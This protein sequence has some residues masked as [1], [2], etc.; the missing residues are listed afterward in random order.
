M[1]VLQVASGAQSALLLGLAVLIGVLL[2]PKVHL[3]APVLSA[4]AEGRPALELLRPQLLPGLIG[5][6]AGASILVVVASVAPEPMHHLQPMVGLPA[7]AKLLYGGITEELML[8]WGFMTL[9]IWLLWRSGQRGSGVPS[10][11]VAWLGIGISAL[12]FGIGHLPAASALFGGLSASVVAY[13]VAGNAAFGIIAGWLYARF[14]LESAM[15][16]HALTHAF[17]LAVS[18]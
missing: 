14:G 11:A 6:I 12:I 16:A 5:G 2:A 4:L 18:R 10:A 1:W 17:F 15:I 9:V 3:A 7:A 13:V 8:R